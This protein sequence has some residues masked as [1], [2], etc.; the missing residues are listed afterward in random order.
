MKN[1]KTK[2][3]ILVSLFV[4]VAVFST[5]CSS[6][7]DSA[8]AS[9]NGDK[10][11]KDEL[12]K[13]MVDQYGLD[14]L[15]YLITQK[16][17]DLEAEKNNIKVTDAD[18]D[19]ELKNLQD[20]YGGEEGF[21]Q[22]IS[23]SGI[24]IDNVKEN[25]KTNVKVKKLLASQINIT[26]EEMKAYFE[27]N[28]DQFA[29]QEQVRARHILVADLETAQEV[30]AKLDSGENF[31]KL[32]SEYSTDPYTKDAGGEL[33]F[34]GKG[35]MDPDFEAAAFSL[36]V[37]QISDPVQTDYG[38]HIIQVEEKK[39][40]KEATYEETKDDIKDTLT[41]QKMQSI[42]DGWLQ[43]KKQEY[44]IENYLDSSK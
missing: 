39:E 15:D 33:G 44:K 10:I 31:T 37:N 42:F 22:A 41:N 36:D 14:T 11:S 26:E 29:E 17:I 7:N 8:V 38:Y 5:G 20:Y 32:A 16:I 12:Y 13:A 6:N 4:L 34:F 21:N 35:E 28:K 23:T 25:L 18:I 24:N 43:Q 3:F 1:L 30:K 2:L 27:Q 40:A 9:V 19:K